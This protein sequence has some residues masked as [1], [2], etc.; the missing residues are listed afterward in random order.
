VCEDDSFA[1]FERDVNPSA[2]KKPLAEL[3]KYRDVVSKMNLNGEVKETSRR[4][5][6]LVG[7]QLS[8]LI[9]E[10]RRDWSFN[11]WY[12]IF[13]KT[14]KKPDTITLGQTFH[15]MTGVLFCLPSC[16]HPT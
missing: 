10:K 14:C 4:M 15:R 8:S 7:R 13:A 3:L 11:N 2:L 16:F 5:K 9:I 12:K 1:V 6:V